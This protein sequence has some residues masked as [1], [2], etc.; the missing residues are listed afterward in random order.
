MKNFTKHVM[1]SLGGGGQASVATLSGGSVAL[2]DFSKWGAVE[3]KAMRGSAAR[4][5]NI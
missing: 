2:P 4:R 3:R 1:S 5:P